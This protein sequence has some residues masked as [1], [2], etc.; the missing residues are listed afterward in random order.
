MRR[1]HRE[2]DVQDSDF[3]TPRGPSHST[4]LRRVPIPSAVRPFPV[5]QGLTSR[6]DISDCPVGGG[7]VPRAHPAG[8]GGIIGAS[9]RRTLVFTC[10]LHLSTKIFYQI[11]V[12][13]VLNSAG[14]ACSGLCAIRMAP[15][16]A[17]QKSL[18]TLQHS[19]KPPK[20]APAPPPPFRPDDA[21]THCEHPPWQPPAPSL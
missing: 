7:T 14:Y 19:R 12:R 21:A 10:K 5:E 6:P 17:S 16:T 18:P 9:N 8:Q 4:R 20:L 15:R 11:A 13:C 1:S 2:S 3:L